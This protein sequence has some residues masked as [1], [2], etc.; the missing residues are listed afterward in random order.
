MPIEYAYDANKMPICLCHLCHYWFLVNFAWLP[1]WTV[2]G[3]IQTTIVLDS[4]SE[5]ICKQAIALNNARNRNDHTNHENA[6][7]M[8][9]Q[10]P[11]I[12]YY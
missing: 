4:H 5:F 6:E 3:V 2:C 8:L 10:H 11:R 9:S 12:I 1:D 7:K